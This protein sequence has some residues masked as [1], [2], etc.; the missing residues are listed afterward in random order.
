MSTEEFFCCRT[1]RWAAVRTI[2]ACTA[3]GT[4]DL[5]YLLQR[6]S[7]LG[8]LAFLGAHLWKAFLAPRLLGNG[9]E[10]FDDIARE[11]HFHMPTLAVYLLGT[12]GVAYHLANGIQNF[13]MAWGIF[14]SERSMRRFEPVVIILFLVLLAMAWGA[15]FALYQA[16]AAFGHGHTI[17]M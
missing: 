7:A 10:A 16:G 9:P 2:P 15:I 17:E 1:A 6:I 11:M 13:G 12:L 8:V 14:A 5:K 4:T 3:S